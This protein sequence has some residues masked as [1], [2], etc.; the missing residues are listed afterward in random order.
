MCFESH[1]M[2]Y[3]PPYASI[4]YLD[5]G[6]RKRTNIGTELL[7]DPSIIMLDEP[8][9]GLD[10]TSAVALMSLLTSLAHDHGKTIITS[11]HQPSSAVFHKFDQVLFLAEGCVVY[12]GTP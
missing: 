10:S 2:R 8:T 6:E 3:L 4:Y 1:Y 9:S 11:I 5:R 7:T 12:Y